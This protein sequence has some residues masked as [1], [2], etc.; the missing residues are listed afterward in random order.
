[1]HD[2]VARTFCALRLDFSYAYKSTLDASGF[3]KTIKP[4]GCTRNVIW[5]PRIRF[6]IGQRDKPRNVRPKARTGQAKLICCSPNALAHTL[7]SSLR[8]RPAIK[9]D[10]EV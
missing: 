6:G 2:V 1:M 10:K 8:A 7:D 5:C 3:A 9:I 4:V